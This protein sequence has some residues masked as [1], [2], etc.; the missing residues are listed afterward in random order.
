MNKKYSAFH[1]A[2]L[3]ICGIFCCASAQ[4]KKTDSYNHSL[5]LSDVSNARQLGGYAAANGRRIRQDVLLRSGALSSAAPEDLALLTERYHLSMLIDL[6]TEKEALL[7]PNPIIPEVEH[8]FLPVLD[9]TRDPVGQAAILDIYGHCEDDPGKIFV[10]MV[11]SGAMSRD[12]YLSFFD[13]PF[14]MAAFR[15]FFDLLLAHEDGAL[16]WHCTGGEETI[17]ADFALTNT[18]LQPRLEALQTAAAKYTDDPL[19]LEQVAALAGVSVPH[20]QLVFDRAHA[21]CGSLLAFVQQKAGLIDEEVR[22][23]CGKYLE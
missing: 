7:N 18:M 13:S 16:M 4:D 11:R 14:S 22:L 15:R 6:R 21:E 17:L 10:E 12:M 2:L 19:E 23:L 20:M 8:V 5:H 3:L 9:E 1:L